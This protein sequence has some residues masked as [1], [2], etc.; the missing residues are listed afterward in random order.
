MSE[1]RAGALRGLR[2]AVG[3]ASFLTPGLFDAALSSLAGFL[4]S[5]FAVR[6]LEGPALGAYALYLAA[7]VVGSLFAQQL[8]YLPSQIAALKAERAARPAILGQTLRPG[9]A[10]SG[11]VAP[12]VAVSGLVVANDVDVATLIA[13]GTGAAALAVVT[14]AQDHV[15]STLYLAGEHN[16]AALMSGAQLVFT[17]VALG[18]IHAA[19]APDAWVPFSALAVGTAGSGLLGL[20][21][22]PFPPEGAL[23][24]PPTRSLMRSGLTL[25][26]AALIQEATVFASAAILASVSSAAL[27]SAEAARIVSR[28]VQ[29]FSLGVS[30]SLAPRLMEAG[31]SRSPAPARRTAAMYAGAVALTGGLYLAAAGWSYPESPFVEVVPV[32]YADEGLVALFLVATI[33]GAISQ[34]P[35]GVLLGANRGAEL[36]G[37][38][39][40]AS[41]TRLAA[42][43]L[44]AVALDAYA[45]PVAHLLSLTFAGGLGLLAV[46][47]LFE[48]EPDQDGR[49]Q[50]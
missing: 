18:V 19:G 35:R 10:R 9:L 7:Y 1:P 47:R 41:V 27:G 20:A 37:I 43:V 26:P 13:L 11:A 30:R 15:R 36:L 40:V 3:N 22:T 49:G 42:V 12:L 6:S 24:L 39:A 38:T 45:L 31:E 14:P 21:I 34:I 16:R 25:L 46:R 4:A 2:R 48:D 5:L 33:A 29:A 32:A 50:A 8:L 28:P 23:V 44:L 17:A